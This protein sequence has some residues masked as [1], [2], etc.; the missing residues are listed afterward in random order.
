MRVGVRWV[1]SSQAYWCR[2]FLCLYPSMLLLHFPPEIHNGRTNSSDHSRCL[3]MLHKDRAL[4]LA[5]PLKHFTANF[6][7]GEVHCGISL[8]DVVQRGLRCP[9]TVD[10]VC[11]VF[12]PPACMHF[13]SDTHIQKHS[14][15]KDSALMLSGASLRDLLTLACEQE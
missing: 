7:T 1:L 13:P 9:Q 6:N 5:L 14:L 11:R 15:C 4:T 10:A 3:W 2:G 12:F 8:S